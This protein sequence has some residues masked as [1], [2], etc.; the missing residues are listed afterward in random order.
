M[1][2]GRK[3]RAYC[4]YVSSVSRRR[5]GRVIPEWN[6]S[7]R[8]RSD[9]RPKRENVEDWA[10]TSSRS[11]SLVLGPV[12]GRIGTPVSTISR[13]TS[14]QGGGWNTHSPGIDKTESGGSCEVSRRLSNELGECDPR[15]ERGTSRLHDRT[16]SENSKRR[17]RTYDS[18]PRLQTCNQPSNQ[19]S[20]QPT[21]S[22]PG[23]AM[24]GLDT[25]S[26]S[27]LVFDSRSSM[28]SDV[29]AVFAHSNPG[30][31]R[32][33]VA[34][35]SASVE[36]PVSVCVLLSSTDVGRR[37]RRIGCGPER[38]PPQPSVNGH[39]NMGLPTGRVWR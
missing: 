9:I 36:R 22:A 11:G 6:R 4:V 32:R 25:V 30:L 27:S 23:V 1:S 26:S 2:P 10:P 21:S 5:G 34:S 29:M 14:G 35:T 3:I 8:W 19:P 28:A 13:G 31:L 12:D 18:R 20:G 39:T 37:S 7:M 38:V 15:W 16:S 24:A 33:F 17:E